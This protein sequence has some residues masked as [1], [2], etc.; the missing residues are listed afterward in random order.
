M[1]L[2]IFF[3]VFA[4]ADPG[5][6]DVLYLRAV[7]GVPTHSETRRPRIIDGNP[8]SLPIEVFAPDWRT[9]SGQPVNLSTSTSE[10][11]GFHIG[12]KEDAFLVTQYFNFQ[13]T[14][15]DL[16]GSGSS[17]KYSP[18]NQLGPR[19]CLRAMADICANT[20]RTIPCDCDENDVNVLE[21]IDE[22]DAQPPVVTPQ[23]DQITDQDS[24]EDHNR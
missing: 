14:D 7:Q 18:P 21:H 13:W 16:T 2:G 12:Y 3:D 20:G 19:L 10:G 11:K 24:F 6:I 8:P 5:H 4:A 1:G 9:G 17:H 23:N 22:L 15:H